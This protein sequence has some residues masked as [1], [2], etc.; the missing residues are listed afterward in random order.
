MNTISPELTF[1]PSRLPHELV[2]RKKAERLVKKICK[3]LYKH[4]NYFRVKLDPF[5]EENKEGETWCVEIVPFDYFYTTWFTQD[6]EW[7]DLKMHF[8]I[9]WNIMKK[10]GFVSTLIQK[11]HGLEKH[12]PGGGCHLHYGSSIM[13]G[14]VNWYARSQKFH[15]NLA[16]NYANRPWIRWLFSQWFADTHLVAVNSQDFKFLKKD[17]NYFSPTNLFEQSITGYWG[18]EPRFMGISYK[19]VYPTFEFRMFSMVRN[20]DEL[21]LIV[22]FLDSWIQH[23]RY[24]TLNGETKFELTKYKLLEMK[25]LDKSWQIC[26][27]YL[28]FLKLPSDDYRVFYNRNYSNRIRFGKL[29]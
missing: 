6:K 10:H 28:D 14:G 18:I 22:K 26:K 23:I 4:S 21:R 2:D 19:N 13:P 15:Q 3:D 5:H 16:V 24:E 7:N 9:L 17:S 11:H 29:T 12:W 8:D 20:P 27:D 25:S 1:I